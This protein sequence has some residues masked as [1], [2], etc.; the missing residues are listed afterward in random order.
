MTD[1]VYN[2][3]NLSESGRLPYELWTTEKIFILVCKGKLTASLNNR[4]LLILTKSSINSW[5]KP[6]ASGIMII[7]TYNKKMV[8][9]H[10][11]VVHMNKMEYLR[12]CVCK[13]QNEVYTCASDFNE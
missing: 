10:L 11:Q 13:D 6:I 9:I 1:K 5:F 4:F 8:Y 2:E 7:F 3:K 12:Y